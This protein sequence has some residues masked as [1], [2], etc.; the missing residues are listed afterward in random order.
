MESVVDW[1]GNVT[2][3]PE[4]HAASFVVVVCNQETRLFRAWRDPRI[5]EPDLSVL[6]RSSPKQGICLP[7]HFRCSYFARWNPYYITSSMGS[8]SRQYQFSEFWDVGCPDR[9]SIG[10][11]LSVSPSLES[12]FIICAVDHSF[13]TQSWKQ[14]NKVLMLH[15]PEGGR[16]MYPSFNEFWQIGYPVQIRRATSRCIF[17]FMIILL[18]SVDH[19][20]MISA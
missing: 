13:I 20:F 16:S 12:E 15:L 2:I 4:F 9:N 17:I 3:P 5:R 8:E 11:G 19:S 14:S 18:C 1:V 10:N 6:C 7:S